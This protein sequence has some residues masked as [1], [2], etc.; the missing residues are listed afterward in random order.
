MT[1]VVLP[2]I[3][4]SIPSCTSVS[5]RVSMEEVASSRIS[6]GGIGHS[7]PGNGQKLPLAL[8]QV[9]PVPCENGLIAV[10]Q[11]LDKIVGI[12]QL[13]GSHTF[14]IGGVQPSISD[15]VHNRFL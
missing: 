14:P 3:R 7:R 5:V 15:I 1:K 2:F 8:A 10:R 6:T 11:T 9:C 12:G 4:R 13:G